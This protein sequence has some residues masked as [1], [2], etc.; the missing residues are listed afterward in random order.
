MPGDVSSLEAFYAELLRELGLH[1]QRGGTA[2]GAAMVAR[3]VARLYGI[4][5]AD[6]LALPRLTRGEREALSDSA[7]RDGGR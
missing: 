3:R 4:E 5:A 7:W 6:R 1:A 2:V